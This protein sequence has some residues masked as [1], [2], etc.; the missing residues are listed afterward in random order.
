MILIGRSSDKMRERCLHACVPSFVAAAALALAA[1]SPS[2]AVAIAAF[3]VAAA[4]MY[5]RIGP[6]FALPTL[7][8]D[9]ASA[10]V[11]IALIST[12]GAIGAFIGP[13]AVGVAKQATGTYAGPLLFLAGAA[14]FS[15]V[16][17]FGVRS[18]AALRRWRH[19][20][21]PLVIRR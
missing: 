4:G 9:G 8:F 10:A 5:G 6:I 3:T 20:P 11:A 12:L 13:Y 2:P 17:M 16:L 21:A 18:N 7:L 15:G 1:Y 19:E 14:F